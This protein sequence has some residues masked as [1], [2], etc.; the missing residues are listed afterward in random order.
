M[1]QVVAGILPLTIGIALSPEVILLVIVILSADDPGTK[2]FLFVAGW[3]LGLAAVAGLLLYIFE[4]RGF[5]P[6]DPKQGV[7]FVRLVAG[8]ILL[9]I[10]YTL[11]RQAPRAGEVPAMPKQAQIS[12]PVKRYKALGYGMLRA[13]MG[14]RTVVL[15]LSAVVIVS[16]APIS[17][18]DAAIALALFVLVSSMLVLAPLV[19]HLVR[20]DKASA[21]LSFW[22]NWA[23]AN[24][25]TVTA[26]LL[27]ILGIVQFANGIGGLVS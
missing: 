26:V 3:L 15:T 27:F 23:I 7:F 19:L 22:K 11:A 8:L 6:E 2:G 20:G 21:N 13:I 14:L 12:L 10:S 5:L 18:R 1:G 4:I 17:T 24:N 9:Y 25:A 16:R